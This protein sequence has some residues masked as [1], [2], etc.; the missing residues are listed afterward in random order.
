MLF[1]FYLMILK[2]LTFPLGSQSAHCLLLHLSF[3]FFFWLFFHLLPL[4]LV[5]SSRHLA[6]MWHTFNSQLFLQL[7]MNKDREK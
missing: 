7:N 5:P 4:A 3:C 1:S 6:C 2:P